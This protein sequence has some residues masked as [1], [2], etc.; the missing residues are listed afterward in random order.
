MNAN[1]ILE[2]L[3]EAL[4]LADSLPK[5]PT[6]LL[7]AALPPDLPVPTWWPQFQTL[8]R[9]MAEAQEVH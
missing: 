2:F 4:I 6:P 3:V 8:I 7:T 1:P 5:D 9:A